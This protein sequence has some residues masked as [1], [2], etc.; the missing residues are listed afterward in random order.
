MSMLYGT[1]DGKGVS[2]WCRRAVIAEQLSV[3]HQLIS[4]D[5]GLHAGDQKRRLI[6]RVGCM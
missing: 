5:A 4:A 1:K 6:G 3:S 2:A